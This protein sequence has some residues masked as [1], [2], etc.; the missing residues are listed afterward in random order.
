MFAKAVFCN[1]IVFRRFQKR[2]ARD[3]SHIEADPSGA[4]VSFDAGRLHAQLGRAD[5]GNISARPGADHDQ[6]EFVRHPY[7]PHL[8]LHHDALGIFDEVLD[9]AQKS[10]RLPAVD[11]PMIIAERHIHHRPDN[12]LPGPPRRAGPLSCACQGWRSGAGSKWAY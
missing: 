10:N 5:G 6:I 11:Y 8:Y 7:L 9:P 3:A 1:A 4:G 12:D 2:L